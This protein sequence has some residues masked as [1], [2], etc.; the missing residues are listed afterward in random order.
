MAG[1]AETTLKDIKV[2][3]NQLEKLGDAPALQVAAQ[4]FTSLMSMH[5]ETIVLARVIVVVPFEKLPTPASRRR[6]RW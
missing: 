4:K 3:R 1:L 5:F 2:I 6:E